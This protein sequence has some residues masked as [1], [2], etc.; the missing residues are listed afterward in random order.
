MNHRDLDN[1]LKHM[2]T[3][4]TILRSERSSTSDPT[5]PE[6]YLP[7]NLLSIALYSELTDFLATLENYKSRDMAMDI[8]TIHEIA[9]MFK[10]FFRVYWEEIIKNPDLIYTQHTALISN[11]ICIALAKHV[12]PLF[13]MNYL[14]LLIPTLRIDQEVSAVM[15][16]ADPLDTTRYAEV[17]LREYIISDDYTRLIPVAECLQTGDDPR[18]WIPG[19][20]ITTDSGVRLVVLSPAE[21]NRVAQHT[22]ISKDF[23]LAI[24]REQRDLTH[25]TTLGARLLQC[26]HEFKSHRSSGDATAGHELVCAKFC[27][28][29]DSLEETSKQELLRLGLMRIKE[30]VIRGGVCIEGVASS[31]QSFVHENS[32]HRLLGQSYFTIIQQRFLSYYG[33]LASSESIEIISPSYSHRGLDDRLAIVESRSRASVA[34]RPSLHPAPMSTARQYATGTGAHSAHSAQLSLVRDPFGRIYWV[35]VRASATTNDASRASTSAVGSYMPG[36]RV[37]YGRV[38][39]GL[40]THHAVSSERGF[41]AGLRRFFGR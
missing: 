13:G 41:A 32:S 22:D 17:D 27:S 30:D 4:V 35:A 10:S 36:S 3:Y 18:A 40:P 38:G 19:Y 2:Q 28:I 15:P 31:L 6:Y 11:K 24:I 5:L 23:Y 9:G 33:S 12:A 37:A 20:R 25:G 29:I 34:P 39:G 21:I 1:I 7:E 8:A 16:S 26:A 14:A